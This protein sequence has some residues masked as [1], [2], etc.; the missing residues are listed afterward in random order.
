MLHTVKYCTSSTGGRRKSQYFS[1]GLMLV[2]GVGV[3]VVVVVVS[4]RGAVVD[5]CVDLL[6]RLLASTD[7]VLSMYSRT[8]YA[9]T[10]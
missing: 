1:I 10:Y 2:G 6:S 8:E 5:G 4:C 3:V 9:L 7:P